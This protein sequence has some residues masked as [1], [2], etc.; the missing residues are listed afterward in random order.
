LEGSSRRESG[1]VSEHGRVFGFILFGVFFTLPAEVQLATGRPQK[2]SSCEKGGGEEVAGGASVAAFKNSPPYRWTCE[3]SLKV[4][5]VNT[6]AG[7]R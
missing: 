6:L 3:N 2:V 4:E 1:L 7:K 5:P